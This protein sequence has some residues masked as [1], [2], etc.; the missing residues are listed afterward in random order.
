LSDSA[1]R[2]LS[3]F[4][5]ANETCLR[6]LIYALSRGG[7]FCLPYNDPMDLLQTSRMTLTS[8]GTR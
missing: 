6:I 8:T 5:L 7:P 1:G 2:F 4:G 3:D